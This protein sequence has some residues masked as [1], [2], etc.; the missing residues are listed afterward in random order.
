MMRWKGF[1]GDAEFSPEAEALL[2]AWFSTRS[3]EIK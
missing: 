2:R 3:I 1:Y